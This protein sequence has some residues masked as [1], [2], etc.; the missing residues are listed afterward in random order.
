MGTN[1]ATR[2]QTNQTAAAVDVAPAEPTL[3]PEEVVDVLRSTRARIAHVAESRPDRSA[4]GR[5]R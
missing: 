3:T 1:E 4:N 2:H 5:V